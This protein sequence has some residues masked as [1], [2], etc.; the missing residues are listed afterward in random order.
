MFWG[1]VTE[2]EGG[3]EIPQLSEGVVAVGIPQDDKPVLRDD[4]AYLEE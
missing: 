2:G 4:N 1:N 3:G